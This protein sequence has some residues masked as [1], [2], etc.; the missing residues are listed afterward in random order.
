MTKANTVKAKVSDYVHKTS[1]GWLVAE[2]V[3]RDS[4]LYLEAIPKTPAGPKIVGRMP[5][6]LVRNDDA[7]T[8]TTQAEAVAAASTLYKVELTTPEV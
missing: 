6:D 4:G 5:R 2:W 8:Y 1:K 3:V 7:P